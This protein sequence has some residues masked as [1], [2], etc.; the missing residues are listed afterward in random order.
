MFTLFLAA[1]SGSP[2]AVSSADS[3]G[4]WGRAGF[5]ITSNVDGPSSDDASN[6]DLLAGSVAAG[7]HY[8][9]SD[10]P[11]PVDGRDYVAAIPGGEPAACN[12]V[13]APADCTAAAVEAL[14]QR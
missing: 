2:D 3:I 10:F 7:A 8:L 5:V 1:C 12:P 4:E 14:G 6:A 13:T 9:A 11:G